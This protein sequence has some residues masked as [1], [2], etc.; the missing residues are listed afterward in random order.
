MVCPLPFYPQK[1]NYIRDSEHDENNRKYWYIIFGVGLFTFLADVDAVVDD[2]DAVHVFR[3]RLPA[4]RTWARHCRRQ[5]TEGCHKTQD[6]GDYESDRV[7]D[8]DDDT[9]SL[10]ACKRVSCATRPQPASRTSCA[11]HA[12]AP[13]KRAA[14]VKPKVEFKPVVNPCAASVPVKIHAASSISVRRVKGAPASLVKKVPL[15][16]DMDDDDNVFC[17]DS[18]VKVPLAQSVAVSRANSCAVSVVSKLSA[19]EDD[20]PMPAAPVAVSPTVSHTISSESLLSAM[21]AVPSQFL[22]VSTGM[23]RIPLPTPPRI[24]LASPFAAAFASAPAA[25][26]ILFPSASAPLPLTS[27]GEAL[28][29]SSGN[30]LFNRKTRV[31]YDSPKLAMRKRK[32]GEPMEVVTAAQVEHWINGQR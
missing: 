24:P 2:P 21:S 25:A 9:E 28:D 15:Y 18:S 22:S 27:A 12:M 13:T 8:T 29:V 19:L 23:R 1:T 30:M 3:S 5:H 31:L 11:E 10:V 4:E 20:E 26:N 7:N 32:P 14:N 17:S 6:L 16:A